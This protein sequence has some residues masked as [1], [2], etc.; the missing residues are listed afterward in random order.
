M[1]VAISMEALAERTRR[2][3]IATGEKVRKR[4]TETHDLPTPKEEQIACLTPDGLSNPGRS[5]R[6]SSSAGSRANG[7]CARCSQSSGSALACSFR[8]R[9]PRK[10]AHRERPA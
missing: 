3:L 4:S 7:I 8:R 1:L 5:A 2:E 10:P 6:S 9:C